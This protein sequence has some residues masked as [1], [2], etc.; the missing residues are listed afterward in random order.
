[1]NICLNCYPD[2]ITNRINK[3]KNR[4]RSEYHIMT[5]IIDGKKQIHN[6]IENKRLSL[7]QK[8]YANSVSTVN[9]VQ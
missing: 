6:S 1:M 9:N 7:A 2:K 8:S 4:K 5:H 3:L